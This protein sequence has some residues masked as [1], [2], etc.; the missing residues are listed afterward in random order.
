MLEGVLLRDTCRYTKG[1]WAIDAQTRRR[2]DGGSRGILDSGGCWSTHYEDW[3][4]GEDH[5]SRPKG[6]VGAPPMAVEPGAPHERD[7]EKI[8]ITVATQKRE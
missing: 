6:K 8:V 2:E 5:C 1:S 4:E 7:D 3:Q